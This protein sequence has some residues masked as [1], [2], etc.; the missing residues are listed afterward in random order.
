MLRLTS[1]RAISA[2]FLFLSLLTMLQT[3]FGQ[4]G[5]TLSGI[6]HDP[7]SRPV[8]GAVVTLISRTGAQTAS[9]SSDASGA[10]QM[11]LVSGEYLLRAEAPGF[12][13]FLQTRVQILPGTPLTLDI[14]LA[15]AGVNEQ[16]TVTASGTPQAPEEISKALVTVDRDEAER[17]ASPALGHLISLAPGVRVQQLGGPGS[18]TSIRQRG[19]REYDT[20]VLIDGLRFRDPSSLH[21]DP[22]ATI[23]DLLT[24]DFDRVEI[25]NGAGSALYGTSAMGGV[26]N[27]LSARGGGRTRGGL[28][29]EG[30]SLGSVRGRANVA[31]EAWKSRLLYSAGLSHW[32]V[33]RGVD[34]DDAFRSSNAQGRVAYRIAPATTLTARMYLG[35]SF[36]KLNVSPLQTGTLPATGIV[37]AMSGVNFLPGPNDSDSTRAGRFASGA[38]ILDTRLAPKLDATVS[39][40]TLASSRRYGDGPAGA[41]FQ[42]FASI[43]TLYNA[44]VETVA[45]QLRYAVT[46]AHLLSAGYEFEYENF[47]FHYADT[48]NPSTNSG[49]RASQRSNA[50]AVQDQ[51]RWFDGRLQLTGAFRAQY[52]A[53]DRPSFLPTASAPYQSTAITGP[54]AAYTGDGSAAYF[55]RSTGTKIRG[56]VG[57]GYR[58]PSLYER[59]GASFDSF[60][61][62]S[63][64]GDPRLRPER[65]TA[66][67]A[68][69]DQSLFHNRALVSAT[70]FYTQLHQTID[71]RLLSGSDPFGRFFGYLNLQGGLSR[72]VEVSAKFSPRRSLD[73]SSSYTFVNA[74]ER[75]PLAG[76][77]RRMVIPR[78]QFS[79]LATQRVGQRMV[80]TFDT[81]QSG[82]FLAPIFDAS[83]SQRIY[84][85]DGLRRVNAGVSY[86]L[87]LGEFMAIRFYGRAENLTGQD[88]YENGFRTP[89]RTALGGLQLEF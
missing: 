57:R 65:S 26:I 46:P 43:R 5:S 29:A 23:S 15:L 11:I 42:P 17:R 21:G 68:G 13:V 48:G 83:F 1:S 36:G 76:V 44:R 64:Y 40:Q 19:M 74:A 47:R 31:G 81:L 41:G 12:A 63:N 6:V 69:V 30:G 20:A 49:L 28:L 8:P 58:A 61:G 79:V 67:G 7:Q 85:F 33:T 78:H 18:V 24:T 77:V 53:L 73:I 45:G 38:L 22:T 27:I 10:Y 72:G 37:P 88:Y 9:A 52:F 14:S 4:S 34:G 60:F 54:P 16:I 82:A 39:Y 62:Y 25:L 86:R 51:T 87:P 50:F 2:R 70:Y 75:T 71:F 56:H 84:R 80:L 59:F 3:A 89:G 35:D 32:N 66:V 55:F